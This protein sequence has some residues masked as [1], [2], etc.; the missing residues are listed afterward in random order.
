MKWKQKMLLKQINCFKWNGNA[1]GIFKAISVNK[2]STVGLPSSTLHWREPRKCQGISEQCPVKDWEQG[3]SKAWQESPVAF[4]FPLWGDGGTCARVYLVPG[5][6]LWPWENKKDQGRPR[7]KGIRQRFQH[8][9]SR[10]QVWNSG[11][12][13]PSGMQDRRAGRVSGHWSIRVSVSVSLV[14]YNKYHRLGGLNHRH[15]FS[16]NSRG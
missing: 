13:C 14:C 15:L 7:G 2:V 10:R 3:V 16:H 11:V 9:P 12:V 5:M 1:L 8:N 4:S 6:H